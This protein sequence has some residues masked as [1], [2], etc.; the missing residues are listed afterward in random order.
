MAAQTNKNSLFL[1]SFIHSKSL[2]KLEYLHNTAVF[3]DNKGA[4]VLI[5]PECDQ[6]KAEE[7]LIPQ[8]GW[9]VGEVN[10]TT[11]KE[12]QF[13]FPGFIGLPHSFSTWKFH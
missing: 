2:D 5:E 9:I 10:I 7:T 12:G 13:F 6:K 4:I 11:A 1:G 8:L 3:V